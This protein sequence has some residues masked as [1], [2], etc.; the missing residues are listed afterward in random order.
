MK[1]DR[2]EFLSI[3]ALVKPG[4]ARREIVEQ[5][6]HFIFTGEDVYTYNDYICISHPLETDFKCSIK[7]EEFYKLLQ[8]MPDESIKIDCDKDMKIKINGKA[9]RAGLTALKEG[10]VDKYIQQLDIKSIKKWR[11][12]PDDFIKGAFLCMF[13]VSKDMTAGALAC[14]SINEDSISSTDNLRISQYAID[15]FKGKA[16][17]PLQAVVEL[18]KYEVGKYYI[19]DSWIHFKTTDDLV[20]SIRTMKGDFPKIDN[21]LQLKGS[22]IVLPN[23]IKEALQLTKIVV[24]DSVGIIDQKTEI[25]IADNNIVCRGDGN[26]G[27]V[28]QDVKCEY[29]GKAIKFLINPI[30]L[31]E[32]LDKT[33]EVVV[34]EGK[35]LFVA[36]KFRHVMVLPE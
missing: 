9:A 1:I 33:K 30:F 13:S 17:L 22:K 14:L 11:R 19:A 18:V 36:D 10:Q 8:S 6:M 2:K 29:K 24:E 5:S 20:F 28:E 31:L 27:W 12:L 16:L 15:G 4:L 26:I 34:G 23:E 32:I 3:L 21:F 25:S 35:A 7:A